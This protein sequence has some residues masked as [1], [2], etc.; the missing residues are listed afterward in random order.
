[1]R[2]NW[3]NVKVWSYNDP[4]MKE[5]FHLFVYLSEYNLFSSIQ[6]TSDR[7]KKIITFITDSLPSQ[8]QKNSS[9]RWGK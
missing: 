7:N 4:V 8:E 9:K 6:Y 3:D 2:R 5:Y 1:M